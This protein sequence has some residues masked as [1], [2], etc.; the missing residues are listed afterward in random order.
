VLANLLSNAV[1][2]TPPGERVRVA[3]T[4]AGGDVRVAVEDRGPGV[5]EEFR[6]SLF[7][8]FSQADA[9]DARQKA[10]TG[11][12]L[13][14][15]KVIVEKLGGTIGHEPVPSGG[16]RFYFELPELRADG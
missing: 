8:K 3:A 4:L 12:G 14:I 1:K 11:L 13:A 6:P 5:P 2:Y 16:A 9:S 7:Q 15:C 10:G